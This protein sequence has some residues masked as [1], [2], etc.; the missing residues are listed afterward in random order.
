MIKKKINYLEDK[1]VE[2]QEMIQ[3]NAL[4][5]QQSTDTMQ[6]NI[7]AMEQ[8]MNTMAEHMTAMEQH[9]NTMREDTISLRQRV[10]GVE[11]AVVVTMRQGF[12]SLRN[13]LSYPNYDGSGNDRR[14]DGLDR[15][16]SELVRK[17]ND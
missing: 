11:G 3:K 1:I 16:V 9:M 10:D 17:A 2:L 14:Q 15:R 5:I 8:H 13:H 12:T 4:A 7:T 6:Q